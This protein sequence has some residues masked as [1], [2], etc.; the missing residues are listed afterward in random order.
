MKS[1]LT[2]SAVLSTLLSAP[3]FA[4]GDVGHGAI[5]AIAEENLNEQG[6]A[7]VYRILGSEPLA[8]AAV[9]PD[10]VRPDSRFAAF[11][12]YHYVEIPAG[13]E[14]ET[15][16]KSM[17]APQSAFTMLDQVPALL[18]S[19]SMSLDQ[20]RILLRYL[21]HI[22]GDVHQPLHVGN[23]IDR[24]G[25]LCMVKWRNPE[26]GAMQTLN[27]H[28][29]WDE[30]LI[31]DIAQEFQR[32]SGVST[33]ADKRWFGYKE[34]AN[35]ALQHNAGKISYKRSS[36]AKVSEWLRESRKLHELVYPAPAKLKSVWMKKP[37]LRDYC[38]NVDAS[39]QAVVSGAFDESKIPELSEAYVAAALPVIKRQIV[40]A[41]FRLAGVLNAIA[42]QGKVPALAADEPKKAIEALLLR[43]P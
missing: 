39:T 22:A 34:M 19:E 7:L 17:K 31:R 29:V 11:G 16:P 5:G 14:W 10:Q 12:P 9:F 37:Q 18:V 3:A 28:T 20:K 25:N 1:L 38:R 27:L 40:L 2:L 43:N 36:Q 24:G 6:R 4:W 15:L 42:A 13:Y 32:A 23:G 21:A 8:A 33:T 35:I 41:G 30:N 26:T